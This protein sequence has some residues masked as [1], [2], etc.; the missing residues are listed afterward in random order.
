MLDLIFLAY[1][2]FWAEAF[3]AT[4]LTLNSALVVAHLDVVEGLDGRVLLIAN[5]KYK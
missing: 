5:K 3:I 1:Q 2:M 4:C